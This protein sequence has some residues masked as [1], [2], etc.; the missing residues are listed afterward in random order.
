M[1]AVREAVRLGRVRME[2]LEVVAP[3]LP[4]LAPI[5]VHSGEGCT[6]LLHH[7][8]CS[9]Q[10]LMM[11]RSDGY[12]SWLLEQDLAPVYRFW[13][14]Q[15]RLIDPAAERWLGASP[16]HMCGYDALWEVAP[17][18][19]VVHVRRGAVEAFEPFLDAVV[20]VRRVFADLVDTFAIA[21][22]WLELWAILLQRAAAAAQSAA[23][24]G[25]TFV[26]VDYDEL[27]DDPVG[28]VAALCRRLDVEVPPARTV[29]CGSCS[30]R[31]RARA[32]RR[33]R[34]VRR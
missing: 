27:Q 18:A 14:A 9:L 10:L 33:L 16:L 12:A 26:V 11:F 19:S 2:F 22:E 29:G 31:A 13:A 3:R 7:S 25:R 1:S 34:A 28:A 4:E 17:S 20:A 32:A 15:L 21:N 23:S 24:V 6:Q 5:S 30:P 8:L